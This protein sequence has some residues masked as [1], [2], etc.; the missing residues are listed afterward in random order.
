WPVDIV[1]AR[2]KTIAGI[3]GRLMSIDT[4][5]SPVRQPSTSTKRRLEA[6]PS[7]IAG[8]FL[9]GG[10]AGI[11]PADHQ[12]FQF[13]ET[14]PVRQFPRMSHVPDGDIRALAGRERTA[15]AEPER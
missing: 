4:A 13:V 5:A 15:V 1:V 6:S 14:E 10:C 12:G 11:L 8:H 7:F 3:A 9:S 2:S